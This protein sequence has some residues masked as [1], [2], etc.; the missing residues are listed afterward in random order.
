MVAKVEVLRLGE[1]LNAVDVV[2][3][4][5]TLACHLHVLLLVFAHGHLGGTVLQDV[6][7]HQ[8]GVGEQTGVH[9][10]GLLTCLLLEGR[11]TLQFAEIAVH[12]QIEV[13]LDGLGHVTLY[14]D[15]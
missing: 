15:G 13:Q 4:A 14:V 10:V 8:R 6:G 5:G 9:V 12:V 1:E 7:C 3:A 2:E 11:H